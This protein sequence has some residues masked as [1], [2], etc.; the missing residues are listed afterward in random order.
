MSSFSW[1]PCCSQKV[2]ES[3]IEVCTCTKIAFKIGA[4]GVGGAE[5]VAGSDAFPL[6]LSFLSLA[7]FVEAGV[8][9]GAG[10]GGACRAANDASVAFL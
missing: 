5:T 8:A 3:S 6:P 4:G 9:A 7:A 1:N 10:A 2:F